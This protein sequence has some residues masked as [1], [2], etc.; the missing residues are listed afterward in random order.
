MLSERKSS[1]TGMYQ[2]RVFQ[3]IFPSDR[4]DT[5]VSWEQKHNFSHETLSS[6]SSSSPVLATNKGSQRSLV[7]QI[8][9]GW[10]KGFWQQRIH[11]IA[12]S[13][14]DGSV[15]FR[16]IYM[17]IYILHYIQYTIIYVT[18]VCYHQF[19]WI[20]TS[21][22]PD[23]VHIFPIAIVFFLKFATSILNLDKS[24]WAP[25]SRNLGCSPMWQVPKFK[26]G[27]RMWKLPWNIYP[28]I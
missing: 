11:A 20:K 4:W 26:S 12:L 6:S 28:T 14:C 19:R 15:W 18:C 13:G 22:R 9:L 23:S 24:W 10:G 2:L 8:A 17:Y 7:W 25:R 1:T 5:A 21:G 27:E 3:D 16:W